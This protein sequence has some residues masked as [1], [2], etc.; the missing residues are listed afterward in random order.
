M[1]ILG[2]TVGAICF[3]FGESSLF[4]KIATTPAWLVLLILLIGYTMIPVPP[5]MD[6]RGW[7]E[8]YPLNGP[9]WSLFF[10][11]IANI[12]HA[13]VL[14][15]MSKLVLSFFVLAAAVAL[16]HLAVTSPNGDIIGGWSLTSDQLKIGFTRLLFPY[17]VGMLLRRAVKVIEG[18]KI[19]TFFLCSLLLVI[20][21]S[22]PRIGGYKN[23]WENGLYESLVI[24]L[25]FPV[26]VYLGAIGEIRG[27]FTT[28]LCIF[29]GDI[30]YPLYITHYPFIYIFSAWV[31]E[32]KVPIN[33]GIFAGLGLLVFAILLA[34][35]A[36][37][38]YDEPVRRWLAG[39]YIVLRKE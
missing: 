32:N 24:I 26:I 16:I 38:F 39:K 1:I 22:F 37:K 17:M 10:E 34:Y 3:Y 2:M 4:P 30:S 7:S 12:I 20:A 5:A 6:I 21:L 35:A 19:K 13:L 14:R 9:G 23:L 28:K 27:L 15:R 29:L 36:L 33:R 25:I 11:Y 31:V 8:T 18:K